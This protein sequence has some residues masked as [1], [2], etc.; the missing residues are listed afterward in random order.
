MIASRSCNVSFA[1]KLIRRW[2][3][4]AHDAPM[5]PIHGQYE[6]RVCGRR[7]DVP[8]AGTRTPGTPVRRRRPVETVAV[9][10]PS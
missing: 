5:W 8:W 6:C 4:L 1:E 10:S 7:F 9:V 2:C 3:S